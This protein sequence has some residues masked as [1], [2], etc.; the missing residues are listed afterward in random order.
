MQVESAM[1]QAGLP[2]HRVHADTVDAVF[3]EQLAGRGQD[4][5][6]GFRSASLWLGLLWLESIRVR[7]LGV[8]SLWPFLSRFGHRCLFQVADRH[9]DA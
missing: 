1:G 6:A 2:H 3:A 5:L 7:T 9:I 4:S 8:K